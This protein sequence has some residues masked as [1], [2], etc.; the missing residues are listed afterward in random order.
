MATGRAYTFA[1]LEA[2]E[3]GVT[4]ARKRNKWYFVPPGEGAES[5]QILMERVRPW[6]DEVDS[7]RFA[8]RMAA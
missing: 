6:L 2:A 8:S 4:K 3:P 7:R 5:Y 1:E